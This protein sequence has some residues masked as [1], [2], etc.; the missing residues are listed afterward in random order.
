[1]VMMTALRQGVDINKTTYV[2]K[3]LNFIDKKTGAKIDVQTDD[4]SYGGNTSIFNGLVKSDNTVFQQL[5]LDLGPE[6]VRQTAY[7]MGI[8][9]HLDAYPAEG[10]GGLKVGVSPLE[11]T[12]AY[13]TINTGGW[14]VNP[15]AIKKVEFPDGHVDTSLGQRKRVKVFTDGQTHEATLAMEANV[16][17]GTGTNAQLGCPTAG[18]TGTT[19]SFTDAWFDGFTTS[20]NT[21]VWVGYPNSTQ[22]MLAVP[23][24]GEMFGGL[25]PALI[26]HDFM[27]TAMQSR[28]CD[29][30]P[31]PTTPFVSAPFFGE[32]ASTGAPG[33]GTDPLAKQDQ[34]GNGTT[35]GKKKS[36]KKGT[37]NYPPSQYESPPQ[38]APK[39]GGGGNQQQS[40]PVAPT[41]GVGVG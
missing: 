11:M 29:T 10:L 36:D 37:K 34:T 27:S 20:L 39:P 21:A 32:Y 38:P 30:F 3:P 2:S 25:A 26:W 22:S 5:D 18:K 28:Q 33:G 4:H 9:S 24:Y 40:T 7:D 13:T 31:A 6:N 19:S 35:K 23:G 17:H 16:D 14:R 12:R 8:T 15:V 41:G 1:M